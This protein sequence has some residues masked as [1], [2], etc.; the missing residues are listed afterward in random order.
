MTSTA[1]HGSWVSPVT[2]ELAAAGMTAGQIAAPSYVGVCGDEVWWVEPRPEED[3][4]LALMRGRSGGAVDMLLPAPWNVRG[5]VIEYGGRAWAADVDGQGALAVFVNFADQRLYAY[6][7][8]L[9]GAVP[10]PLTPVSPVGG[11]L[12]WAE[13]EIDLGR[14]EVRCVLEE[15]TGDG[16]GDVRRVIAAVPLDGSAAEDRSAVRELTDDRHRFLSG[17]RFSPDGSR[18]VW[19]VWDHPHMPWDA[20]ALRIADVGEDGSLHRVRTLLGGPGDPVAQAEWAADGSLLVACERTGWWNLY[21]VDPETGAAQALHPAEEEFAGAQRLGLRWFAPLPD[22]RVAVLHGVGAQRLG[23]LDPG[24]GELADVPGDRSEWLPHLAVSGTRIFGVAAGPRTSYEV[25]EV[26]TATM[27]ARAVGQGRRARTDPDYFPEPVVRAF[28]GPAGREV[29]AHLYAPRNPVAAGPDGELPPYVIWAHGGPGLRAP[30]ALNLEIAYFTSRGIGVADVNYGGTPGYGRAY[31][32]RLR[33]EW[34]VVDVEDCAAVA[35]AL[36]DEGLTSAGRIAI[37]GGSAGGFTAAESLATTDVYACATLLYPVLDLSLLASRQTHDFESHYL[38]SLVGPYA[39][40]PERYRDR[41]PAAHPERIKVPF[42]L[43]Q[44]TDDVICP[45]DQS[46]E[47]LKG[48]A[49]RSIPHAHC[50]FEG[51]GHGFRRRETMVAALEAELSLYGQ[52]FGFTPHGVPLLR[53][54]E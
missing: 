28:K 11:G 10:Q 26:D 54:E 52:V 9:P 51:E 12:R 37:R 19:S 17:A 40:V 21:R 25:V 36:I 8:D 14:A 4:R 53:L 31:H 48:M 45:P 23:V 22:G 24:R 29:H 35:R 2:A 39:Q 50:L 38:E 32:E 44:G 43:L 27:T 41:S 6:R 16:P 7:A 20:A 33:E 15:F 3:G 47:F 1:P 42:L 18:A 30:L 34:G 5:R 46:E 13:P 49:G